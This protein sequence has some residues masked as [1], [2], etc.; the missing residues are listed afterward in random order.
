M[1]AKYTIEQAAAF[2]PYATAAQAKCLQAFV[3]EGGNVSRAARR[4]GFRQAASVRGALQAAERRAA[5]RGYAPAFGW[6]PPE[7]RTE[8]ANTLPAGFQLK[9][10]SELVDADGDRRGA[11]IKSREERGEPEA[12]PADFLVKKVSQFTDG[13]GHL[14]GQWK[15]FEPDKVAAWEAMVEAVKASVAEF[16][17][18]LEPVP[19]PRFTD[20][21]RMALYPV[22]DPH[23]GMLAHKEE[24]GADFDLKIAESDLRG[25]MDQVIGAMPRASIGVLILLGDNFHADDDN[26]RTPAHH[27]K[28]DVDGRKHKVARVGINISRHMIDRGLTIHDEMHVRVVDGNHDPVTSLWLRLCLEGWYAHEPRVK[29]WTDPAPIQA[30]EFGQNMC[31]I[32]HGDGV[33]PGDMAGVMAAR[34]REMWGR[35]AFHYGYQ[36]HKHRREMI[37][38]GGALIEVMRTLAGKDSFATK[39]GYD[40]GQSLVGIVLHELYGEIARTT[41]DVT[42]ARSGAA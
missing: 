25:A 7:K 36:G 39:Y 21:S 8:P 29:V 5:R 11:W 6:N 31:A 20:K 37:E 12:P 27:H 1:R 16:V 41:V 35:T 19:P 32:A 26:Q 2:I 15:A 22:G 3:D 38:K 40:S 4:L 23:W 34:F 33:K 24:T 42:L 10:V 9:G 13:Q 14:I 30:W 28:L 17:R 18:P